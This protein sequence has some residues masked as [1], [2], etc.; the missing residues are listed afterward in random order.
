MRAVLQRVTE[1]RVE[2]DG[3][4]TGTIGPGLVVLLGVARSDTEDDARTLSEK[5]VTLRVFSDAAGKMNLS[6]RDTGGALL[7]ISQFTLLGNTS[8]G[9][10]P[11]YGEAAPPEIAK[12]LYTCFVEHCRGLGVRT[13]VGRFQTHMS[14]KLVND[15]PVTLIVESK[16]LQSKT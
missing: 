16:R 6:V 2:A 11:S 3:E 15:G 8:K 13:E 1:A 4:V 12:N 7:I 5:I 10:R 14:V 9:R